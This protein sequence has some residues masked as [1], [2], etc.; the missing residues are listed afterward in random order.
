[1]V[2]CVQGWCGRGGGSVLAG[3]C[4]GEFVIFAGLNWLSAEC[5]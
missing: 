3:G 5:C 2:P 1:M 4:L